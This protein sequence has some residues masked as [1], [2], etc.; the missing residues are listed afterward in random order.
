MNQSNS[1]I[2]SD[3]IAEDDPFED[4]HAKEREAFQDRELFE[5]PLEKAKEKS[6]DDDKQDRQAKQEKEATRSDEYEIEVV[7]DTPDE[8]KGKWVVDDEKDGDPEDLD[9][10][11]VKNY[12][13][14]VQD[15]LN[16]LTARAHAE[17]RR[18]EQESRNLSEAVKVAQRLLQ[19]NNELK[20]I[21]ESGEKVLSSEHRGRLQGELE[22]AKYAYREAIEAGDTDGQLVAHEKIARLVSQ[23]DR[24][25]ASRSQPL[26]R[27][28]ESIFDQFKPTEENAED[29]N[30]PN[31]SQA[32]LEWRDKNP[33]FDND[34]AMQSHA[35]ATHEFL[36]GT[37]MQPDTPEY[38][39]SIDQEMRRKFPNRFPKGTGQNDHNAP[40]NGQNPNQN[41]NPNQRRRS[42]SVVAPASRSEGKA[43][44]KIKLTETQVR[45]A[46]RLNLTPEQYAEQLLEEERQ[47]NGREF[48]H[49]PRR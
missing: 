29:G 14:G 16:K 30:T 38:Y 17:R 12:S 44:R 25:S 3:F 39:S 28:D 21:V 47:G 23:I 40:Q 20:N 4:P 46:R 41:P 31:V 35:L 10:D 8:D 49:S 34:V 45:L 32:A 2:D 36:V 26:P 43:T 11:E 42:G 33:W 19:E 37:G 7:D 48:T 5:R 22:K 24:V 9:E 27:N 13:K 1:M 18:R 6:S 15:R